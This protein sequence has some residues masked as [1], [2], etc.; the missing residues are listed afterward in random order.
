MENGGVE[1]QRL[2]CIYDDKPLSFEKDPVALETNMETQDTL[3]EINLGEGTN[4]R[5]TYINSN[6]DPSL[7]I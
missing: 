3:E 4:K 7:R 1:G 5:L 2:D 6:I